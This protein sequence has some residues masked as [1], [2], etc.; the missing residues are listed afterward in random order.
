MGVDLAGTV[1]A[2]SHAMGSNFTQATHPIWSIMTG[3]GAVI[4][5]LGWTADTSWAQASTECAV[6]LFRD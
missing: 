1:V 4:L 6:H 5:L 3:C 2:A